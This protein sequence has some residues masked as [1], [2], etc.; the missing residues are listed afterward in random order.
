MPG[1]AWG[2]AR[3]QNLE[4]LQKAVFLCWSFLE[5]Y[6]LATTYWKAFEIAKG[7][8]PYPHI[9]YITLPYPYLT[10]PTRTNL[11]L[12]L[13]SYTTLPCPTLTLPHPTLPYLNLP[14]PTPPKPT[15]PHP[16]PYLLR[17][18]THAHNQAS[19]SRATLSCDSSY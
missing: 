1:G 12:P 2:G 19:H 18:H 16:H 4:H 3:G 9:P 5:V 6:I 7:T 13:P 14:F 15:L 8:L 10:Y 17:I 11:T